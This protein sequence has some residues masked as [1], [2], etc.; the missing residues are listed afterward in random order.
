M[1]NDPL[2]NALS[3]I[4][5]NEKLRKPDCLIRISSKLIKNVL[6]IIN[7]NGYIGSINEI[8]ASKGDLLRVNLLGNINK[9]GVIRPRYSVKKEE[10]EKFE[11]R[12]LPAKDIGIL[13]VSTPSG[14]MTHTEAKKKGL[15]GVLI[16]YCY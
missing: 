8:K 7:Q 6:E 14:L 9:C 3:S 10:Y 1:L 4:L 16:A 11:K 2:A 5:N 15:G 12:Y 13:I